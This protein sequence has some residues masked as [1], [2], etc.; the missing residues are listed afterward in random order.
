MER[1]QRK[2]SEIFQSVDTGTI[3]VL[4]TSRQE[5]RLHGIRMP[6]IVDDY[7]SFADDASGHHKA[8]CLG[9]SE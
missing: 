4:L 5:R 9:L 1:F 8:I 6:I 3:R 2:N 7:F